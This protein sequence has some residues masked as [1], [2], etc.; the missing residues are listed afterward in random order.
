MTLRKYRTRT[1]TRLP[2]DLSSEV[3]TEEEVLTKEGTLLRTRLP[4]RSYHAK[5]VMTKTGIRFPISHL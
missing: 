4:R 3:L 1:R 5:S 2:S